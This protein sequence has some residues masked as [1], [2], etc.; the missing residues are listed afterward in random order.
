M[1]RGEESYL[2]AKECLRLQET[3]RAAWSRSFPNTFSDDFASTLILDFGSP[4]LR[5]RI[6][7]QNVSVVSA[8][9]FIELCYGRF[10]KVIKVLKQF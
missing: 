10:G 6:N 4:E 8:S 7:P 3:K 1:I 5:D 9:Q 2:Q